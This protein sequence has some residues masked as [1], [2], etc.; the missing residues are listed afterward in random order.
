MS[1]LKE[2][3]MQSQNFHN[4]S[5]ADEAP[6]LLDFQFPKEFETKRNS[7]ARKSTLP[8]EIEMQSSSASSNSE[9]ALKVFIPRK[10]KSKRWQWIFNQ[11]FYNRIDKFFDEEGLYPIDPKDQLLGIRQ[12]SKSRLSEEN[13]ESQPSGSKSQ[14]HSPRLISSSPIESKLF[15]RRM[16]LSLNPN[17]IIQ[18]MC[19]PRAQTL[20]I[21]TSNPFLQKIKA[22]EEVDTPVLSRNNSECAASTPKR[23]NPQQISRILKD[24]SSES[25][26][27]GSS[28]NPLTHSISHESPELYSKR[29]STDEIFPLKKLRTASSLLLPSD[30]PVSGRHSRRSKFFQDVNNQQMTLEEK[31]SPNHLEED[32]CPPMA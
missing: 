16:S 17:K 27:R 23:V 4:E 15:Q 21:K 24:L 10:T 31:K 9:K 13:V 1:N 7:K 6:S 28:E 8:E 25:K 11:D 18:R 14:A 26:S 5:G 29:R 20:N 32:E 3:N 30:K 22:I 12:F 19:G 2:G